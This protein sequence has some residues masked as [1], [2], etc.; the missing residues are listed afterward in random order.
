MSADLSNLVIHRRQSQGSSPLVENRRT[1]ESPYTQMADY[2]EDDEISHKRKR[3][4]TSGYSDHGDD[5][6]RAEIKR[7]RQQN[8]EKDIRLKQ[9]EQAVMALQQ[10][11]R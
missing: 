3:V 8:E 10:N 2:R 11:R 6:L 9:L 1:S 5:D 4:S 7:L